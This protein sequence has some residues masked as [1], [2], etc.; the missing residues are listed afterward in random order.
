[1]SILH[2]M[3]NCTYIVYYIACPFLAVLEI[4]SF[5]FIIHHNFEVEY[6]EKRCSSLCLQLA[7]GVESCKMCL[8]LS[9]CAIETPD[10]YLN[11]S[12]IVECSFVS[13]LQNSGPTFFRDSFRGLLV[14]RQNSLYPVACLVTCGPQRA[15]QKIKFN[16]QM[17]P[18]Y[19]LICPLPLAFILSP[20]PNISI[21][22][23]N[24][25]NHRLQINL[26]ITK[27]R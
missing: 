10:I 11:F 24:C 22:S 19:M 4:F 17:A 21:E 6:Y 23:C 18:C 5:R 25:E 2:C 1:M 9:R 13:G 8:Q 20:T 16:Y 7:V 26:Q 12:S 27:K 15:L 14:R 3:Y